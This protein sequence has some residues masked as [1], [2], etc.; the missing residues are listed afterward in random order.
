MIKIGLTIQE[1]RGFPVSTWIRMSNVVGLPHIEFDL[2]AFDDIE[3][4]LPLLRSTI[5]FHTPYF[6]D[7]GFDLGS[8]GSRASDAE[9]YI[10]NLRI[11][12]E[13]LQIRGV[14]V[15]PPDDPNGNYETYLNRLA[16]ISQPI[17]LENMPNQSWDD[18]LDL[19]QDIGSKLGRHVG[20]CFDVPHSFITNGAKFLELPDILLEEL[21]SDRGYIHISGG[22]HNED[23]HLPLTQGS[24]PLEQFEQFVRR[25]RFHGT[26]VMELR[27]RTIYNF[28]GIFNSFIRM[29]K[30]IPW[31]RRF[32]MRIRIAVGSRFIMRKVRQLLAEQ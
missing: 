3:V 10:R 1:F 17:H 16:S 13:K 30:F 21:M 24:L 15:H 20:L 6:S 2:S 7:Y 11:Y 25:I 8:V 32:R 31:R 28:A 14:V 5:T 29:T 9:R 19:Y 18:F 22:N 26:L 4:A 27:P 23:T 12:Q